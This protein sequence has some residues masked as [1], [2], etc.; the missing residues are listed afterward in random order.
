MPTMMNVHSNVHNLGGKN[1]FI[2]FTQSLHI[3]FEI[4][5]IIS[6]HNSLINQITRVVQD[7][8]LNMTCNPPQENEMG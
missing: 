3:F 2:C 5:P 8:P 6:A 7:I 1:S 4:L